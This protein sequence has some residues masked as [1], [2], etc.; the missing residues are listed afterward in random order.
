M[1]RADASQSGL[2]FAFRALKHRNYRLFFIGQ[3]LSLIGTWITR[4]AMGWLVYR[5][6]NSAFMLGMVSFAGLVPT[7]LLSPVGGVLADRWSR[8]GILLYS[9][10]VLMLI[11][12]SLAYFARSGTISVP[13]ILVLCTLQGLCNAFDIPTR[14]SFV[15]EIVEDRAD[16]SGAIAL[17]STIF[18]VARLVGPSVAGFLIYRVG[19]GC[20]FLID[21]VSFMAVL[22]MLLAM[23]IPPPKPRA[24]DTH[25]LQDLREGF[26]ASYGF[27]PIRTLLLMMSLISFIGMPYIILLPVFADRVLGGGALL[28]GFLNAAIGIGA[29]CGALTL[30]MRQSVLGLGRIIILGSFTFGVAL[31]LFAI[32]RSVWLSLPLLVVTGFT[33]LVQSVAIHTIVQTIVDDETRGRVLSFFAMAFLGA[34]PFG[35]LIA[36]ALARHFSAPTTVMLYGVVFLLAAGAFSWYLPRLKRLVRPIYVARGILP[37]VP[38]PTT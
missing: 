18:N 38:P 10:T 2:L 36:G 23:R 9:Q 33:L 1:N 7:F 34:A 32:S 8:R 19:E 35:N 22:G 3:T 5:L 31:I 6:T 24:R 29:L 15:V 30:A 27:P 14:Q 13:H 12:L 4:V 20:C 16:L 11:S 25:V 21:G 26:H 28:L 37:E 17:N